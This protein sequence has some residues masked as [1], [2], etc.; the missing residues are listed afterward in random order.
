[1]LRV[2][3]L[4]SDKILQISF[5]FSRVWVVGGK[6]GGEAT[7]KNVDAIFYIQGDLAKLLPIG[8][9]LFNKSER[10]NIVFNNDNILENLIGI[11]FFGIVGV[12]IVRISFSKT[13]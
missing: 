2:N 12:F 5:F 8:I 11:I 6:G 13:S 7:T 1:M 3:R 4:E 10:K 9:S